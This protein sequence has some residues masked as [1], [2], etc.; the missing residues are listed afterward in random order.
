MCMLTSH[1]GS[2]FKLLIEIINVDT[3]CGFVLSE[4]HANIQLKLTNGKH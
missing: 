3:F 4:I 1:N 2:T